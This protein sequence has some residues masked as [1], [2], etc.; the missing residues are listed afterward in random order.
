MYHTF[1]AHHPNLF[2]HAGCNS[3]GGQVLCEVLHELI[4]GERMFYLVARAAV[5]DTPERLLHIRSADIAELVT[6]HE[7]AGF[8][9]DK[10]QAGLAK[11]LS[12]RVKS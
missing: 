9:V 3:R 2:A 7:E 11:I 5:T 4:D 10:V 1:T 8:V 6:L 12:E